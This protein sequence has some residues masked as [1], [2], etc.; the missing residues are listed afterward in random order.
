M[1]AFSEL[2]RQEKLQGIQMASD[3]MQKEMD[4]LKAELDQMKDINTSLEQ[5]LE[6]WASRV[7]MNSP[8]PQDSDKAIA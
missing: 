1:R 2:K 6:D 8:A 3:R 5:E 4:A 7:P